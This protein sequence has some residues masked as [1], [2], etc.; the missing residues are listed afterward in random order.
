MFMSAVPMTE[1]SSQFHHNGVNLE[2]AF[3]EGAN[4]RDSFNNYFSLRA[5]ATAE[6]KPEG[7]ELL[8]IQASVRKWFESND[9]LG[10]PEGT[11][12]TATHYRDYDESAVNAK[13]IKLVDYLESEHAGQIS[14]AELDATRAFVDSAFAMYSDSASAENGVM[15]DADGSFAFVVPARMSRKNAEYG[16][17]V[18][19]VIPA[20]RY[21][22]NEMRAQILIGLPPFVIDTYRH[23]ANGRRGYLILA[24]VFEDMQEDIDSR[25]TMMRT[26]RGI[27]ND[28][29]DFAHRRFGVEVVGLGA[30]LPS[31]TNYGKTIRNKDVITTTGHGGTAELIA[32]TMQSGLN[33]KNLESIGVLGLGAIGASVAEIVADR[34]PDVPISLF[35]IDSERA[36][37]LAAKHPERFKVAS[38]GKMLIDESQV[39]ISAITGRFDVEAHE[40]APMDGK[41]V[42]D[43]AQPASFDPKQVE[44]R[45]GSVLWVIGKDEKGSVA[46]R[47]GYDYATLLGDQ[48]DVFGCEAE[49]ASIVKYMDEL[50]MRGM[51]EV[52]TRRIVK[53]VAINSGVTPQKVRYI[54]ALFTKYGIV[55]SDPQAFGRPVELA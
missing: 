9:L 13:I 12:N 37:R 50:R 30:T 28:A 43:D 10:L 8:N 15:A 52:L 34:Y 49:A 16:A 3:S 51:G 22:P 46:S 48:T 29:V 54:S 45:G 41:I 31:L 47:T 25:S 53:K 40:V 7:E 27:V 26:A 33:G 1:L 18:E 17:E 19:P 35:D 5:I 23:D 4:S 32:L 55:A 38:N 44:E 11:E 21:L 42:V 24:P 39:V 6:D 2:L 20:L 36:L 14:S